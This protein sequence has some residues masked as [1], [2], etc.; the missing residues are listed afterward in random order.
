MNRTSDC[1]NCT[2]S[3]MPPHISKLQNG[4]IKRA[5]NTTTKYTLTEKEKAVAACGDVEKA[6]PEDPLN[7]CPAMHT[8]ADH[9]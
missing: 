2:V 9:Q 6:T 1:T 7:W 8:V 4:A 5:D 3:L